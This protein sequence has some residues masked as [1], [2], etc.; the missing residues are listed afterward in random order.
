[1]CT[2]IA[3]NKL[4]GKNY[5]S[6]VDLGMLFTNKRGQ[7]KSS[8]VFPPEQ[9]L[10]W[11]SCYGS[12]TFS[13]SGKELPVCGMNEKGLVVEQATLQSSAYPETEGKS[14]LSSLEMT[15][16]LLDTCGLRR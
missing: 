3:K 12:I 10:E 1:M 11:V 5:D 8:A 7:I 9:P 4:I 2:I 6:I 16:Y 13:Q 15:Q 14:A